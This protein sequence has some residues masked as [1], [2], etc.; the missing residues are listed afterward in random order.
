MLLT[1]AGRKRIMDEAFRS[2]VFTNNGIIRPTILID[3]FVSGI[4]KVEKEKETVTLIIELFKKLSDEE[5]QALTEEGMRLL[6]FI[7]DKDRAREIRYVK[8]ES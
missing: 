3:G 8:Q 7:A 2:N 5:N 6:D 4:W 1:Y